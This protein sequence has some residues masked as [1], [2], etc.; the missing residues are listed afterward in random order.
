MLYAIVLLSALCLSILS[1]K[2]ENKDNLTFVRK[3]YPSCEGISQ[4]NN[5]SFSSHK[6]YSINYSV[7]YTDCK[8]SVKSNSG[9]LKFAYTTGGDV[10]KD[11]KP[12]YDPAKVNSY[13]E[14]D[15]KDLLSISLKSS[16]SISSSWQNFRAEIQKI[17]SSES[18]PKTIKSK[19]NEDQDEW[20][21]TFDHECSDAIISEYESLFK[22]YFIISDSIPAS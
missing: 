6:G 18:C 4:L 2:P 15:W 8:E 1:C 7:T 5:S 9:K 21:W 14:F 11:V 3:E 20:T 19:N 13:S 16:I 17:Q 22:K 10:K 12:S